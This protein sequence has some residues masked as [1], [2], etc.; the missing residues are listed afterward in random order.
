MKLKGKVYFTNNEIFNYEDDYSEIYPFWCRVQLNDL[1]N[2]LINGLL[3]KNL[4]EKKADNNDEQ[5]VNYY[6]WTSDANIKMEVMGDELAQIKSKFMENM[7]EL[8]KY[9]RD[10]CLD[11]NKNYEKNRKSFGLTSSIS[12]LIDIGVINNEWMSKER[13]ELYTLNNKIRHGE[14]LED[15]EINILQQHINDVKMLIVNLIEGYCYYV[16]S[17]YLKGYGYNVKDYNI[18]NS[19]FDIIA[20]NSNINEGDI[21][22]EIK[23]RNIYSNNDKNMIFRLIQQLKEYN[24]RTQKRNKLVLFWFS[25]DSRKSFEKFKSDFYKIIINE[26]NDLDRDIYLFYASEYRTN[27]N[28]RRMEVYLDKVIEPMQNMNNNFEIAATTNDNIYGI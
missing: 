21:V 28:T 8:E 16:I 23:Y 1:Y 2:R 12:E 27:F 22:F 5:E 25:K 13:K 10:I 15:K 14:V 11:L 7:I 20:E 24:S 18:K 6:K 17:K 19:R 26:I 3:N 4:L 9:C